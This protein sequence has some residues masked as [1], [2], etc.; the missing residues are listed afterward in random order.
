MSALP[1]PARTDK[2]CAHAFGR[3]NGNPPKA[4]PH[5]FNDLPD[6]AQPNQPEICPTTANSG[7]R[8]VTS[9]WVK[10]Q[11]VMID[12]GKVTSFKVNLSVTFL[13]DD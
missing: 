4:E 10:D 2:S 8:N 11:N 7:L 13:L 1:N 3:R 12:D 5:N 9:A 6:R